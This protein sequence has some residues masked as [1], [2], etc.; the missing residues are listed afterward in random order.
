M[1]E[2]EL[3]IKRISLFFTNTVSINDIGKIP[4]IDY[5]NTN[6]NYENTINLYNLV[7]SF[8]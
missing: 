3:F 2:L 1:N 8:N 6:I 5:E 7:K 4:G